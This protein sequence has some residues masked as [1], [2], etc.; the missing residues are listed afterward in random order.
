MRINIYLAFLFLLI[1]NSS[2]C[3]KPTLNECLQLIK[4]GDENNAINE[5][6]RM[7]YEIK[8]KTEDESMGFD[9]IR[10]CYKN[11]ENTEK[12]NGVILF[13]KGKQLKMIHFF[14]YD[15]SDVDKML[16]ESIKLGFELKNERKDMGW[17]FY[18]KDFLLTVSIENV[19]INN[20]KY[21]RDNLI[22]ALLPQ[23]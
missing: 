5:F 12:L 20:K 15:S 13:T 23:K 8:E 7:G 18:N 11:I 22:M 16:V 19:T 4:R 17:M 3:Q 2:L 14:S 6:K 21:R 10:Y 1:N 9:S